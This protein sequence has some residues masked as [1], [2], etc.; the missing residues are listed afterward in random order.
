MRASLLHLFIAL[1]T[2]LK[3]ISSLLVEDP[4]SWSWPLL[5]FPCG[6][7]WGR[8]LTPKQMDPERDTSSYFCLVCFQVPGSINILLLLK[9]A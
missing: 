4:D 3:E 7:G 1:A 8:L 5:L 9:I 6:I 2:F